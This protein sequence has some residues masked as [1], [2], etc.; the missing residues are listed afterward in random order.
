MGVWY[1]LRDKRFEGLKFRRQEP[2]EPYIVDFVCYEKS[3][4]IECDG[5]QHL[6]EK[7]K[8]QIRDHWFEGQGYRILRFWDHDVLQNISEVLEKI[9]QTCQVSPSP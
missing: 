2:I 8:D 5:S 6:D 7:I 9:Y 1:H 4:I 3:I